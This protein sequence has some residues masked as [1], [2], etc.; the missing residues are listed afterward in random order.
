MWIGVENVSNGGGER[1]NGQWCSKPKL[2]QSARTAGS[3]RSF[4]RV[5]VL[6]AG[7]AIE[8]PGQLAG[9]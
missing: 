6:F 1:S 7:Y 2:E 4:V 5:R 9:K 8:V 3:L